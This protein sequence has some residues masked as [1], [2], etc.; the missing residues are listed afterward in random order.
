VA[1]A[2]SFTHYDYGDGL[3]VSAEGSADAPRAS[4]HVRIGAFFAGACVEFQQHGKPTLK[5]YAGGEALVPEL[6][7]AAET[8][9]S[10]LNISNRR[11]VPS[12]NSAISL[13]VCARAS[14][15]RQ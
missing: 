15:P 6:P 2:N 1:S 5:V 14:S 13:T 7:V 4:V 10:G 12:T 3:V 8:L 9:S 11:A